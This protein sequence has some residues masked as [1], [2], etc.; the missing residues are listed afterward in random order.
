DTALAM[1]SERSP[2]L[3]A[4]FKQRFAQ[5]TNPAIDPVR[6]SVVMSVRTSVGPEANL[7]EDPDTEPQ[8]ELDGPVI[9]NEQMAVIRRLDEDGLR[10]AVID[11]TWP[12]AD[13]EAGMEKALERI[14]SEA[15]AAIAGGHT[16][17]VLS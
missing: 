17:L 11:I 13:G 7:F 14:C 2:S 15:S 12:L 4:Y 5:V 3:F 9:T 1:L 8:L 6:E 16:L 10:A